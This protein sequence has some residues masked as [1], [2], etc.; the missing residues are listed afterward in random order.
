[1]MPG[2]AADASCARCC[3]I[4]RKLALIALKSMRAT[5]GRI[6]GRKVSWVSNREILEPR[7]LAN[8]RELDDPVGA[9]ALLAHNKLRDAFVLGRRL[10]FVRIQVLPVN[11]DDD[12]GV[13][14]ESA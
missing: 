2:G 14:F 7:E 5:V 6:I 10:A 4:A 13:L 3:A 12:I 11:K 8:E 9:I 1:M